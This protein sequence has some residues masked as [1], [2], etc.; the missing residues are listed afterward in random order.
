MRKFIIFLCLLIVGCGQQHPEYTWQ[1]ENAES[2]NGM[3]ASASPLA[4]EVGLNIL[5]NGGN[6]IDAAIGTMLALNV[7]EPNA[8]GIGGGGF[9]MVKMQDSDTP[10]MIDYR[11][12]APGGVDTDFYYDEN[13]DF[14]K[15]TKFGHKAVCTPGSLKGYDYALKNFGTKTL[16]EILV[17][18]I[19]LAENGFE[20]SEKFGA[21]IA[22]HYDTISSNEYTTS[23]FCNDGLPKTPGDTFTNKDLAAT[24]R[25]IAEKGISEYYSGSLTRDIA[26]EMKKNN[27]YLTAE[28]LNNFKVKIRTPLKGTYKGYEI[29]SAALPSAGGMQI[30]Q[31]LNV[32]ENHDLK[33]LGHNS[34]EYINL[35]AEVFKQSFA[36]RYVYAGDPDFTETPTEKIISKEYAKK[37][38]GDY[39]PA[40]ARTDYSPIKT[41][42]E[43]ISTSHP[44][45]T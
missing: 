23:L 21:M 16:A 41:I 19:E 9:I 3:V 24:F 37:I 27:G 7:V 38:S 13:T 18:V 8:S 6:A 36:D 28:D 40:K 15:V 42:D 25:L 20:I 26:D 31:I 17:P 32:L 30:I 33:K 43:S 1:Y 10:V 11:E 44:S 39:T 45:L 34:P 22:D 29:F 4:S 12:T 35:L 2:D 5:K 14:R